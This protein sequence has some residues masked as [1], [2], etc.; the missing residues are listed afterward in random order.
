MKTKTLVLV[1]TATLALGLTARAADTIALTTTLP[2]EKIEGT[3]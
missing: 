3:T 2:P 1:T